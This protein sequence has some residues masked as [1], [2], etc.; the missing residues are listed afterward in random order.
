MNGLIALIAILG[1]GALATAYF[2]TAPAG[3]VAKVLRYGGP[4]ILGAVGAFLTLVGRGAI[5]VPLMA[6]GLAL[7]GRMRQQSGG[8]RAPGG[9]RSVVRSAMLEME[10]DHDTGTMNGLVLAG[11]FEGAELDELAEDDLFELAEELRDDRESL[12][13]LE[14]YLDR[15]MPDWRERMDTDTGAGEA[16]PR[17]SGAMTHEEAYQILG[18]E[19][20][21]SAADIRQAHRRLMQRLHPDV[22]GNTFLAARI[23]E[24]KDILLRLHTD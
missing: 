12:E 8:V 14:A 23:N 1:F 11:R 10:L 16:G 15:R 21:A 18:L 7:F 17:Q 3:Q 22:G 9:Q 13:L 6:A 20:G 2:V 19:P 4:V 24:A 5:G